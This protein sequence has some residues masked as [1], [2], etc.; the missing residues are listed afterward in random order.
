ML[1]EFGGLNGRELKAWNG[2]GLLE[3]KRRI[4]LIQRKEIEKFQ[5]WEN[6]GIGIS[7]RDAKDSQ[8]LPSLLW[9]WRVPRRRI[10]VFSW[11]LVCWEGKKRRVWISRWISEE[12]PAL[13]LAGDHTGMGS[14]SPGSSLN[15]F[16]SPLFLIQALIS[17]LFCYGFR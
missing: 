1:G 5:E 16:S 12:I 10:E 6:S 3:K 8:A 7:L 15:L 4:F 17:L 9:N 2:F 14:L 13:S 11:V